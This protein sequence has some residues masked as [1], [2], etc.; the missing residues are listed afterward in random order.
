M[1]R[2][3]KYQQ[4]IRKYIERLK[5]VI[6]RIGISYSEE[7]ELRD[8][9]VKRLILPCH[10]GI[11][12]FGDFDVNFFDKIKNTLNNVY[13]SFFFDIRNLGGYNFSL[14]LFSKGVKNEYKEMKKSSDK[15]KIHPTNKFYQVLID[16]R[17]EENLGMII[18]IIDLPLYSSNDHN[19]IFLFGET[20]LKHRCCVVSSL[21]LKEQFYKRPSNQ[22]L[23][24]QRVIKEAVHEIGHLILGP[25]HCVNNSCVMRFSQEIDEIDK[26]SDD[27][28]SECKSK[29]I[30]VRAYHNF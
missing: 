23:Y 26:K 5:K 14:E 16:K 17:I 29:L 19:I 9:V 6:A 25:D 24:E 12:F 1:P 30:Q 10:L 21:K 11:L 15:I 7:F 20:H 3:Q 27:F 4:K 18:A 28:C 13:D 8:K 2:L 22:K